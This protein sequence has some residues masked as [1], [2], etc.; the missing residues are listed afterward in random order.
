M[1]YDQACILEEVQHFYQSL[2]REKDSEL[3]ELD[4]E[5]II[6]NYEIPKLDKCFT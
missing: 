3:L 5:D 4:H 1:I 6:Q 2:Y